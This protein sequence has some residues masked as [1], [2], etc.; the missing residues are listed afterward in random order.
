MRADRQMERNDVRKIVRL[1]AGVATVA[2]R[3]GRQI[4]DAET[5]E[6][7]D[8]LDGRAVAK[9]ARYLTSLE[10]AL[11]DVGIQIVGD[12]E[13]RPRSDGDAVKVVSYENRTD[14]KCDTYIETLLPTVR[15]TDDEGKTYLLQQAETVVGCPEEAQGTNA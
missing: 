11:S 15:W 13:G 12:Y 14:L 8:G 9:L 2:W 5:G 6:P 3:M 1:C 4:L 7:K 10:G